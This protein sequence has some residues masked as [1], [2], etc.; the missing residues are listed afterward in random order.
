MY[1]NNL[2]MSDQVAAMRFPD[3]CPALNPAKGNMIMSAGDFLEIFAE[4]NVY[5]CVATCFLVPGG[6]WVNL[7]SLLYHYSGRRKEDSI[8]PTFET[9]ITIIEMI[10]F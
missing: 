10:G 6:I 1:D 5:D 7:G 9:L 3:V 2:K 4:P 8:E